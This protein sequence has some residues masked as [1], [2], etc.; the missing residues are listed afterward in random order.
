MNKIKIKKENKGK[1]TKFCKGKVTQECINKGKKSSNPVTRKRAV[2]A[3]NARRWKHQNGGILQFL[4]DGG[5]F[6]FDWSGL[7]S[8]GMN[9]IGSLIS[10][11]KANKAINSQISANNAEMREKLAE[12]QKIAEAYADYSVQ[13]EQEE[14]QRLF[15]EDSSNGQPSSIVGNWMKYQRAKQYSNSDAIKQKYAE[16]N[17]QLE[18]E[19][20]SNTNNAIS[21]ALGGLMNFGISQLTN[22]QTNKNQNNAPTPKV[23]PTQKKSGAA[24]TTNGYNTNNGFND[25][26]NPTL[27]GGMNTGIG[28]NSSGFNLMNTSTWK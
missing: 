22:Y 2:F 5:N 12:D 19:S 26:K 23:V 15:N 6:K 7:A 25:M 14:Q 10:A 18:A 28:A 1:F 27:N 9:A 8:T 3:E 20:Q 4:E 24:I 13:Q 16:I 21:G 11:N 17:A